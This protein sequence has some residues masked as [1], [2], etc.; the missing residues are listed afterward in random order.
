MSNETDLAYAAGI[1]DG[2]GCIGAYKNKAKTCRHGYR[3]CLTIRVNISEPEPIM[4]LYLT[5]GGSYRSYANQGMGKRTMY[6]W[7]LGANKALNFLKDAQPYFKA[8]SKQVELAIRFRNS[9][10]GRQCG[11]TPIVTAVLEAEGI[12]AAQISK[13]NQGEHLV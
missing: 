8:K 9:K 7:A 11:S 5:F 12:L 3:Y 1:I 2:D 6:T 13:I 10:A 4:W